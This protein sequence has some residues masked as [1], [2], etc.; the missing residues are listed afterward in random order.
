MSSFDNLAKLYEE[1]QSMQEM[2]FE[3]IEE[4]FKGSPVIVESNTGGR[5]SFTIDL[6]SFI[7]TEAWG[8]PSS[9]NREQIDKVFS[10]VRG[11]RSM[12]A[13]LED[14]NKE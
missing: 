3:W 2:L 14:I 9:Q 1:K 12:K 10:V 13:K 5:F 7:P 8:D 4:E 6:P 11:G